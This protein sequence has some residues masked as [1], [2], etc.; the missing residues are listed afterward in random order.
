M[1]NK[2]IVITGASS[3]IGK[4]STQYLEKLGFRV[5]AGVRNNLDSENLIRSSS[6]NV[7]PLL[8]DIVDEESIC[9]A[10]KTVSREVGGG[11]IDGLVC[12]AGIFI[13]GPLEC[14]PLKELRRQFEVNVF[15]QIAVIQEFLPLLRIRN[16]RIVLIGS[17][18]GFLSTPLLGPYAASKFA[19]RALADSL[20][21]ELY[22]RSVSV[23][24]IEPGNVMT[25]M[26]DKALSRVSE[27]VNNLP[28]QTIKYYEPMITATIDRAVK[29]SQTGIQ[30]VK[31][32]KAIYHALTDPTP[33]TRYL[34][35]LDANLQ[36]ILV[37][38]LPIWLRDTLVRRQ[39]GI[40]KL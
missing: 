27:M 16:G 21:I 11:G 23:S 29:R 13:G 36:A 19:L 9:V 40:R 31:V 35:G 15:G 7:I 20:R 8:L 18:S 17:T 3:G 5:F 38:L 26:W 1:N 22:P 2:T 39:M 6:S 37:W 4:A 30:P 25:P 28:N 34:V 33:K 12:N 24:L 10:V 14:L 32:A